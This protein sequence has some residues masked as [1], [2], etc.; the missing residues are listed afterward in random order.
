MK[1]LT[2]QRRTMSQGAKLSPRQ[3]LPIP[4]SADEREQ[5][6]ERAAIMEFD[7]GLNQREAEQAALNI[8]IQ[9]RNI[10]KVGT[11]ANRL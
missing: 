1:I 10:C 6:I 9:S 2:K 5:A 4:L 3:Y 8:V 11:N 7:G